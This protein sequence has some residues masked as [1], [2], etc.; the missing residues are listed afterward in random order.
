MCGIF[1]YVGK[2]SVI[3]VLLKG[4]KQ[5]EY[6]GYDSAG[7][8][9]LDPEHKTLRIVKAEGKISALEKK[10]EH[11][12]FDG[13]IG[14][15]HTR[16]AT[17]G[18]PNETNAHPQYCTHKN[19]A[20]VHNGIIEN[21]GLLRKM[22]ALHDH[23]FRSET[24]TE[25]IAH[26]IS[27]EMDSC[28]VPEEEFFTSFQKALLHLKG[29]Y[30]IA[31]L[32]EGF[33]GI[34]AARK[35]SPLIVGIGDQEFFIASDATPINEYTKKII[36]LDD[37]EAAQITRAGV[38]ITDLKNNTLEKEL[39]VIPWDI[40]ELELEG[41]AYFMHKEI[42]E[43]PETVRNTFRGRL[44][45]RI[46]IDGLDE[47]LMRQD[48]F[49]GILLREKEI[50][51][52]RLVACGTSWH[53]ALIGKYYFEQISKIAAEAD[54]ASEFRYRNP[55]FQQSLNEKV[56]PELV[57]ALSQSG[58]TAD[59]LEAVRLA[60]KHEVKTFGIVNV[61]GSM[62]SRE[63][64]AGIYIHAGP[65]RGVAS[66]KAFTGQVSCLY[67]MA[68][69]LGSYWTDLRGFGE[70]LEAIPEQIREILKSEAEISKIALKYSRHSNYLFLGRGV[71]FPTALEGAL[72]LKEIS[73][74]HAEGY[75]AAEMKHG[76][77]ALIDE[78]MPVVFIAP[79]NNG[80]Y[81]KILNNMQEVKARK[82]KIITVTDHND[83]VLEKLSDDIILVPQTNEYLS[84]L[85]TVIPLQLL[86]YHTALARGLDPDYPRNLAK[87]VTVE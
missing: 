76:P 84:P 56:I 3:P 2:R 72:K 73:G 32:I 15:A 37:H 31:A 81:E 5:L 7:I 8:A 42:H 26:L 23:T 66:T 21:H 54:Y 30:G 57:I 83:P 71:N 86:A 10:L 12:D 40:K 9:V 29:T 48:V 67:L 58:E 45:E 19:I 11:R 64:D 77:I 39:E 41:H 52:I 82:G 17:H 1:G 65:E 79:G 47:L 44:H 16:W 24:D 63:T 51:R 60:K 28:P 35:G 25:T 62:I 68:M 18:E 36:V 38:R 50:Q 61:P 80:M 4:L 59:T 74:I 75:P 69:Y 27:Q 34:L 85:L 20:V 43:Q 53:A 33:E 22:L 49:S 78:N 14:I 13:T 70:A 46:R 55:V 87:A 6:R